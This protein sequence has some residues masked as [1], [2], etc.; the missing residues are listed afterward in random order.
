MGEY[1]YAMA[2]FD[3][4]Q[5]E[6]LI[7]L[8]QAKSPVSFA[9]MQ[10]NLTTSRRTIYYLVNKINE[11]L[12]YHNMLPI[13]NKRG[14]GYYVSDE[15]KLQIN[16]LLDEEA[17]VYLR[18]IERTYYL[19][20]WFLYPPQPIHIETIMQQFDI[21]R[22][23]VFNDLKNVKVELQNFDL[24]LD[25]DNKQGYFI[26]GVSFNKRAV[27]LYYLKLLLHTVHYRY[28][29]FLNA[30]EVELFYKRLVQLSSDMR[31]EFDCENLLSISCLLCVIRHVDEKFDF[32]LMELKDL[33]ETQELQL[34]D[35]YFQDFNV[36]ERLYLAVHLLGSKA[37]CAMN[38][39]DDEHDIRLFELVQ[40]MIDMFEHRACMRLVNKSE[41]INSLYMHFK[42]SM[43]YYRL[44]IQ[45]VNPL[46]KEVKENY[47]AVY[48]ILKLI[49]HS[50]SD[51]FPFPLMESEIVYITMHF[52][53]HLRQGSGTFYRRIRLLVVC[54]S[55]ISTSTLLRRE[56]EDLYS[57]VTVVATTTANNI[58]EYE[59]DIDFIVST[60]DVLSEVPWIKVNTILTNIDKSRIASLMMLKFETYEME[61][62]Q[63]NGLFDVLKKYVKESD[64]EHM[65]Q[66]VYAY[67]REGNVIV[68]V[69]ETRNLTIFD[70]LKAEDIVFVNKTLDWSD[71]IRKASSPLLKKNI[72]KEK[73][74]AAMIELVEDYGPYIVLQ[75][76]VAIAHANPERGANVLGLSL[77]INKQDIKFENDV[78]VQ[79]L[80]VL[81]NPDQE[82]HLQLLHDIMVLS[83]NVKLLQELRELNDRTRILETLKT[84]L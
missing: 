46:M 77:L 62:G 32:S 2:A 38:L 75:N 48:Q 45:I 60:I 66:D 42:L 27:L 47:M 84:C 24:L 21:S 67:V 55:G 10:K 29:R 59:E 20:C 12:L 11:E 34:I 43:Y 53:G 14:Q 36:H 28:L 25:F 26:Q 16:M 6:F 52:G 33:K 65:K 31:N 4:K 40:R 30:S 37:S 3:Y 82:K 57:N 50:L 35:R 17:I 70:I 64:F 78:C 63:V 81:S 18:P 39:Q 13:Q 7:A 73:Y 58:I 51:E 8:T 9:Q 72:I 68:K 1:E 69:E 23:S 5:K 49:C 74:I 80:F 56:I 22:N 79:F 83:S 41:L 76:K 19:I 71:S 15:Q 54:P 44:S 61:G